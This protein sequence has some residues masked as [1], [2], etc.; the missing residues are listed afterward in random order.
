MSAPNGPREADFESE[1]S[2]LNEG[3]KSCHAVVAN[4]RAMLRGDNDDDL[5]HN[6]DQV[7]GT[8][9]EAGAQKNW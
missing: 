2:K 1:S 8:D 3:L 7:Y 6:D 5:A 9:S 4:Y